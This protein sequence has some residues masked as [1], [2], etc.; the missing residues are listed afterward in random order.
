[1]DNS[2]AELGEGRGSGQAVDKR[3]AV[4]VTACGGSLGV[5]SVSPGQ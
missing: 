1:M 2:S 4:V 3:E 5:A